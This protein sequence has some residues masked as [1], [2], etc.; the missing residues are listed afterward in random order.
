LTCFALGLAGPVASSR[1]DDEK[2]QEKVPAVKKVGSQEE[3]VEQARQVDLPLLG[4]ADKVVIEETKRGGQGRRVTLTRAAD[5]KELRE[6]LRPSKASP[7]GGRTAATV[8][9]YRGGR[10][11]RKVW[12]FEGGEWGFERPG[13]SWTTGRQAGLWKALQKHLK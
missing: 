12:V 9:F 11:L 6:A 3:A 7:S 5:L 1:G 2:D 13:T 10:V 8:T 4:K